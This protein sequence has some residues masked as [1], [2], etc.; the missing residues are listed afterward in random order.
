M[1]QNIALNLKK[2]RNTSNN[3]HIWNIWHIYVDAHN[4]T[5]VINKENINILFRKN[6]I[7]ELHKFIE[8]EYDDKE[9]KNYKQYLPLGILLFDRIVN[10]GIF[11]HLNDDENTLEIM[12]KKTLYK[13]FVYDYFFDIFLPRW[14]FVYFANAAAEPSPCPGCYW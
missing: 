9:Y 1:K 2:L 13:L 5:T 14:N 8:D 4:Y 7:N 3:I 11:S 10:N 6:S 12:Y